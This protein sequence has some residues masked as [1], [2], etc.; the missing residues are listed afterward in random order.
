M[1]V[2]RNKCANIIYDTDKKRLYQEWFGFPVS[3]EFR[4]AIN[5]TVDFSKNHRIT[6]LI[7]DTREHGI[8][9][10]SDVE[11]AASMMSILIENGLKRMAFVTSKNKMTLFS[12][13][14]FINNQSVESIEV[15]N[16]LDDAH[17]WLE[18]INN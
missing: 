18:S 1:E 15:F 12:V 10:Q 11:Y 3:E 7:T 17:E 4:D 6:A 9:N 5:A 14:Y 16:D 13:D 2:F 8:V